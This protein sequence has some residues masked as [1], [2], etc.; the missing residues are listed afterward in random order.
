MKR[1]LW[2]VLGL[3]AILFCLAASAAQASDEFHVSWDG[4]V[5][6]E[7]LSEPLFEPTVRWVPGDFEV[8][9]FYVRNQAEGGATLTIAVTAVDRDHLMV[10]EDIRLSARLASGDWV[11]LEHTEENFRLNNDELPAGEVSKVEVRAYFDSNSPNRS[12]NKELAL[13]FRVIL[14]DAQVAIENP[15]APRA[16]DEEST[17][18]L[19]QTGT[20]GLHWFILAAGTA[21]GVGMAVL[22]I[23]KRE[24]SKHGPSH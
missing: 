22:G 9:V 18:P 10:Y 7:Q 6:S 17:G 14:S 24:E 1:R 20:S 19:P 11:D 23:R 16:D 8:E 21:I 4:D 15:E 5:W 13:N 2:S 3:T 12:Q